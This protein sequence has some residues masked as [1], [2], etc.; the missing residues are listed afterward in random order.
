MPVIKGLEWT[1]NTVAE[2]Y[3][4]LRPGYINELYE[5]IFRYIPMNESSKVIEIG[6]GGGQATLPILKTGCTLT[7][8]EYGENFAELCRHKF[9]EYPNFSVVTSKFEDFKCNNNSYDLIY[10]ASAFHWIPEEIGYTKIYERLKSGGVFARF[11][12][13]PY[14]DKGREEIHEALQ[15]IY[16]VYMPGGLGPTEYSMDEAKKRAELALKYGFID[17]SYHLYHR[18]RTFTAKEYISLLGTYSDHIAIE[19][20]TRHK[21]FSEIEDAINRLGGQITIYDTIDLQLARKP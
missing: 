5:D 21:F 4:K 2:T 14:K 9:R 20:N 1:F 6:I 13:H 17:V 19:E 11:A 15:K 7:A 10:S 12:N 8:V 18:T 16:A 3:E